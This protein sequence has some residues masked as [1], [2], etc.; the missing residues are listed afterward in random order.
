MRVKRP[1]ERIPQPLS[2]GERPCGGEGPNAGLQS[3][4]AHEDPQKRRDAQHHGRGLCSVCNRPHLL[5]AHRERRRGPIPVHWRHRAPAS[6][7]VAR[8]G[9]PAHAT[10]S[11]SV[12]ASAHGRRGAHVAAWSLPHRGGAGPSAWPNDSRAALHSG[13]GAHHCAASAGA[14]YR[15]PAARTPPLCDSAPAVPVTTV[16]PWPR[17]QSPRTYT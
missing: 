7:A 4:E 14:H 11:V 3:P 10:P 6:P 2:A 5:L 13:A 8:I 15:G 12:S 17:R 9:V 1:L 16:R